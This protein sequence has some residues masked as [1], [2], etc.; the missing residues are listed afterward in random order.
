MNEKPKT[1]RKTYEQ[2]IIKGNQQMLQRFKIAIKVEEALLEE[3]LD[4][5]GGVLKEQ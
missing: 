4:G 2:G 5:I 3:E 1:K